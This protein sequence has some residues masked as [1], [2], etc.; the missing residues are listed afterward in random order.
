[1]IQSLG[2]RIISI[3]LLPEIWLYC[4]HIIMNLFN[5]PRKITFHRI[6]NKLMID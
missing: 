3:A 5:P 4:P 2:E 1:M 6:Q